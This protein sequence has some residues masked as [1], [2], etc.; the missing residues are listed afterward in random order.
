MTSNV[1]HLFDEA[2]TALQAVLDSFTVTDWDRPSPCDGWAARDVVRH[3]VDT[4]RDYFSQR[5]HDLGA[6]S[7]ANDPAA[8]WREHASAVR[9]VVADDEAMAVA[10]DGFFGPT[11]VGGTFVEFYVFDMI[12]HRWDLSSA[13]GRPTTF[14]DV[15]MDRLDA[16]AS[17][18]GDAL[19]MEGVC[20]GGVEAPA[21]AD[22]Q[23]MFLARLGRRA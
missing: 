5:G 3:L 11:T 22:R 23:T 14:S 19:Y 12:V 15:E 13:L 4:E 10:Y 9:S 18:W 17:A 6:V 16:N 8:Q 1:A 20:K 21:G 2:D 7:N